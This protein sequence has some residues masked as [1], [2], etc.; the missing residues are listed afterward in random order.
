MR[1]RS[2]VVNSFYIGFLYS[3]RL[4]FL[5]RKAQGK[6]GSDKLKSYIILPDLVEKRQKPSSDETDKGYITTISRVPRR[7][8]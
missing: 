2:A 5:T 8:K 6:T 3:C 7:V 4:R 1:E